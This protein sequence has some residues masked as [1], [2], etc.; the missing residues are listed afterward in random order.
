MLSVVRIWLP[1]VILAAGLVIL[2]IRRDETGLDAFAA[3]WGAGLSVALLNWLHRIGVSGEHERDEE[4]EARAFL[5]RH[6][7]WPDEPPPAKRG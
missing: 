3:L 1:A 6:G 7:H 5:E 4:D 2:L